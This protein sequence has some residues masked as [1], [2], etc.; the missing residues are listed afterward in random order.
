MRVPFN[1]RNH[2]PTSQISVCA[3]IKAD[4]FLAAIREDRLMPVLRL[5]RKLA[6]HRLLMLGS[7]CHP[8]HSR[9]AMSYVNRLKHPAV[10]RMTLDNTFPSAQNSH[11]SMDAPHH[12]CQ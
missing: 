6:R 10:P 7:I 4:Q 3:D 2:M 1:T 11:A 8:A 5:R 12:L 9:E